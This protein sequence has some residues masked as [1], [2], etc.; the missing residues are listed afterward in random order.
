MCVRPR[1]GG[2]EGRAGSSDEPVEFSAATKDDAT[3]MRQRPLS[4]AL[5]GMCAMAVGM[6]IG[7]FV[8]TPILPI[9]AEDLALSQGETG[10]IASANFLGYLI[11]ALL[12]ASRNLPGARRSWLIA[13]LGA[14]ALGMAVMGLSESLWYFL[15]VRFLGGIASA[16]ILVFASALVLDVLAN[17]RRGA[18]SSVHF[19]GVGAGIAVSALAV[20]LTGQLE[21]G[22]TIQWQVSAALAVL[23]AGAAVVLIPRAGASVQA[24]CAPAS[25][26]LA[27]GLVKLIAAYGLFG[28]GYIITATFI[29][30]IVRSHAE[31]A[32]LEPVIW[33]AVGLVAAPSVAL[34][35]WAGGRI[36][37]RRAFALACLV[38]AVGVVASV[39]WL[40]KTGALFGAVLLG[41][42]FMGITA[43]GL[44]AARG[45]TRGDARRS[46]GLMT[47]AFG[48]GQIIG[49]S[50]AGFVH[51]VTGSFVLPSLAA[52]AALCVAAGLTASPRPAPR[53]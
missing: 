39:L 18:M 28:F 29:V 10:L 40:T 27:P 35:A 1:T 11:G 25:R 48:L 22:W 38:E 44:V 17:A 8:Y 7:R 12:A 53:T 5:G 13:A 3:P 15:L 43:L 34:W 20:G 14:N 36:G 50:F 6:G 47:A 24:S 45:L 42:T 16:F 52:A 23:G 31:I 32:P 33:I 2:H 51:D 41:G 37:V 30:A 21:P 9:M 19:A 49:P 46:L 26:R 4:I